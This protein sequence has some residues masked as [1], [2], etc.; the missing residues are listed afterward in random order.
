MYSKQ[1]ENLREDLAP[2]EKFCKSSDRINVCRNDPEHK[3]VIQVEPDLEAIR[4]PSDLDFIQEGARNVVMR[5]LSLGKSD[6]GFHTVEVRLKGPDGSVLSSVEIG[7]D[8]EIALDPSE[9][10]WIFNKKVDVLLEE[11]KTLRHEIQCSQTALNSIFNYGI[12]GLGLAFALVQAVFSQLSAHLD[13]DS[14]NIYNY[15]QIQSLSIFLFV[16]LIVFVPGVCATCVVKWL[17]YARS[18]GTTGCHLVSVEDKL[19]RAF[20][21]FTYKE[22]ESFRPLQ[23]FSNLEV[24]LGWETM[25]R[26]VRSRSSGQGFISNGGHHMNA[27]IMFFYIIGM[28]SQVSSILLIQLSILTGSMLLVGVIGY[29]YILHHIISER[30]QI[31]HALRKLRLSSTDDKTPQQVGSQEMFGWPRSFLRSTKQVMFSRRWRWISCTVLAFY[32]LAFLST[33]SKTINPLY[34]ELSLGELQNRA[35]VKDATFAID[36]ALGKENSR[37]NLRRYA[38]FAAAETLEKLTSN[39]IEGLPRHNESQIRSFCKMLRSRELIGDG[40]FR[41]K[42]YAFYVHDLLPSRH[43]LQPCPRVKGCLDRS[44]PGRREPG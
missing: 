24:N 11:Y 5:W 36:S 28:L 40:L 30:Q 12:L 35:L 18:I 25:L 1:L 34:G 41:E 42:C 6:N 21:R 4:S 15:S 39:S 2:L 14:G 22:P 27:V 9:A 37:P 17:S 44:A 38:E 32:C 20:S 23:L 19:N 13:V 26:Q 8:V 43:D 31:I 29:F 16:L 7:N 33:L 3:I 10:I